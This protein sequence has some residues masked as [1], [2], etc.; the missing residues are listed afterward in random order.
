MITPPSNPSIVLFGDILGTS[1]CFPTNLPV[2]SAK[3][4]VMVE[5]RSKYIIRY[6]S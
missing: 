3:V 6:K 1:L 5:S 4:S 2:I